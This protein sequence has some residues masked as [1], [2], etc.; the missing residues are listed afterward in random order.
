LIQLRRTSSVAEYQN[1]FLSLVTRCEGLIEKRQVDIFIAGLDN[2]LKT[3]VELE[4]P[5]T[6]EG[7]MALARTYE[8]R[9]TDESA[10]R[11]PPLAR[12]A[13][14]PQASSKPLLL[15]GTPPVGDAVRSTTP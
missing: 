6:L 2:P 3:Y 15:T 10:G 13:H 7:M 9:F 12:V 14:T 1:K 11:T 5:A 4:H 8:Q